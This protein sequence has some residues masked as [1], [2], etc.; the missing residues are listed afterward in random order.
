MCTNS[1]NVVTRPRTG[2]QSWA[3][4]YVRRKYRDS[5]YC[6]FCRFATFGEAGDEGGA[7]GHAGHRRRN[8]GGHVWFE[9]IHGKMYKSSLAYR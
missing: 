9:V 2:P 6:C 5:I 8:G 4:S 1:S 7:V 3:A